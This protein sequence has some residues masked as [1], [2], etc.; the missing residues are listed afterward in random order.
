[1]PSERHTKPSVRLAT[2]EQPAPA[3]LAA[4]DRR[5]AWKHAIDRVGAAISILLVAPLLAGVAL[6]VKLSG[7]GPVFDRDRRVTRDGR[8]FDLLR[9]RIV[10]LL[11]ST[12]LDRL[13]ELFNVLKGEM[14]WVGPRPERPEF[15]ELFGENLLR[16]D[17]PRRVRPGITGWAQVRTIESD[18]PLAERERWDD[19]YVEHWSLWLDVRIVVRTLLGL[20]RSR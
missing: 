5:L 18:A 11:A 12:P 13:P 20:A 3:D 1:M 9:F 19:F 17:Q 2:V 4:G 8:S 7:P 6:I 15:V 14:S 16:H 10:P